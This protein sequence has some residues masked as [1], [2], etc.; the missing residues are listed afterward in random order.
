MI[1]SHAL[2]RLLVLA[3]ASLW[4]LMPARAQATSK[5]D[6]AAAIAQAQSAAGAWLTLV[7]GGNYAASFDSAAAFFRQAV[8]P[9]QWQTAVKQARAPF[10]PLSARHVIAA[11]YAAALPNAP[12]G[13]Y[14]V[15]QYETAGAKGQHVIETVTPMHEA[16]GRWRVSGYYIKPK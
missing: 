1:R 10:G 2:L 6:T 12:P 16:N 4:P 13:E 7:D 11:V 8:T 14:V 15:L 5:A 9:D 3:A